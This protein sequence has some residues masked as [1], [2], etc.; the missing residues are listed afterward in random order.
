MLTFASLMS[1]CDSI[2]VFF[3]PQENRKKHLVGLVQ[4]VRMRASVDEF[5]FLG[6]PSLG[7]LTKTY[8]HSPDHYQ[9]PT[10]FQQ[11]QEL[12]H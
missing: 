7:N 10:P 12:V 4:V 2:L 1:G 5:F 11:Q 9:V 6:R 8:H 3:S